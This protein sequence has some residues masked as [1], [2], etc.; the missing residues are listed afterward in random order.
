MPNI[1]AGNTNAPAMMMGSRCAEFIMGGAAE[2]EFMS[3]ET[4][5]RRVHEARD[6]VAAL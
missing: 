4:V 5:E 6:E 3:R 2:P 1:N